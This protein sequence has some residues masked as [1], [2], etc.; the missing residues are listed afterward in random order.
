MSDL[1]T[2]EGIPAPTE[3][4]TTASP[5]DNQIADLTNMLNTVSTAV[6][7]MAKQ[8]EVIPAIEG[9]LGRLF[10]EK[11]RDKKTRIPEAEVQKVVAD[12]TYQP[13]NEALRALQEQVGGVL[14]AKDAELA[15]IGTE[16]SAREAKI[17][18]LEKRIGEADGKLQSTQGLVD[19]MVFAKLVN[20]QGKG[21]LNPRLADYV[22][23]ELRRF[24]QKDTSGKFVPHKDGKPI[25]IGDKQ[26][27]F[28]DLLEDA[29][30]NGTKSLTGLDKPQEFYLSVDG[31]APEEIGQQASDLAAPSTSN[32][33]TNNLDEERNALAAKLAAEGRGKDAMK[34]LQGQEI[35]G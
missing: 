14:G 17:A 5:A 9:K 33:H 22:I 13:Q 12:P 26:A 1:P 8:M 4:V 15:K 29:G 2:T 21:L 32:G 7:T 19:D 35:D 11:N 31:S 10:E 34:V 20:D 30:P 27:T 23:P 24:A 6:A 3:T 16:L 25:M 18:E 28:R